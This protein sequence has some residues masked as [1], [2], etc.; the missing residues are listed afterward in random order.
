MQRHHPWF[1]H[2]SGRDGVAGLCPEVPGE[3]EKAQE[4]FVGSVWCTIS[5][6]WKP[7]EGCVTQWDWCHFRAEVKRGTVLRCNSVSCFHDQIKTDLLSPVWWEQEL[8]SGFQLHLKVAV[9]TCLTL[10]C[11]LK[12]HQLAIKGHMHPRD[13]T[14]PK[15]PQKITT[16]HFSLLRDAG[17]TLH[18][19]APMSPSEF[20]RLQPGSRMFVPSYPV[21]AAKAAAQPGQQLPARLRDLR[22]PQLKHPTLTRNCSSLDLSDC[23]LIETIPTAWIL[24]TQRCI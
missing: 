3:T 18:I 2:M 1:P 15:N 5:V 7:G 14:P 6:L 21:A 10:K 12:S 22:N 17:F 11:M 23:S 19:M 4:M 16:L 20:V 8:A 13:L 9:S 24:L